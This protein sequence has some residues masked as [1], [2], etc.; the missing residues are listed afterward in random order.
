M[1]KKKKGK[2]KPLSFA[3]DLIE[4]F[5]IGMMLLDMNGKIIRMN[6]KQEEASQID[7]EKILGKTFEKAF[8]RTLEQGV[9]N[10][11]LK[12]LKHGVPFDVIIDR[13][14]PQYYSKLI[15]YRARG[16]PFSS[17]KYYILLH[18][19]AEELGQ[20]KRLVEKRTKE[21]QE[22]KNFLESMID[23]SPNIVVSTN[24]NNRI[25]IFNKTAEGTF[26]YT[27]DEVI[28]RKVDFL[29]KED[30]FGQRIDQNDSSTRW[31]I[32][33]V[34]KD[35]S[36]FPASLRISD[37]KNTR[38][39]SIAKLYL[40]ADLTEK[41][42]MEERLLLSEKLALYTE[43]MGGIAHQLNNPLIG[44]INFSEML[45]SEIEHEDPKRELVETISR[46]GKECLKIITSV[47]DSIKD[48]YLT[49][50]RTNMNEIL[51]DSLNALKEQFGDRVSQLTI[52]TV[53]DPKLLPIQGD[54]IQLK[55]CIL[56]IMTNAIQAMQNGGSLMIETQYDEKNRNARIL[57]SDTGPGIP[58]EFESKIFLPYFSLQKGPGRHG[59]G[60]SFAFQI[61]K[62][63]GG[64][65]QVESEV[66]KGSTFTI[67]LPVS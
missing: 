7:R 47:L 64:H 65:I 30:S 35:E 50:T 11:Y 17:R 25:L 4:N 49:F 46:A 58:K 3:E 10:P 54:G 39:R 8:P 62:N 36:T 34:R 6:K 60:L 40:L 37:I 28:K 22:S 19:H 27:E 45:L 59:L 13:Y 18:E 33:C 48:P 51:L 20:E 12:L 55:Q 56:N 53:T 41:K 21:V 2:T 66:G 67:V 57:F 38:G 26:G 61:V 24:F 14:T 9:R 5:P 63:H 29:F 42:E 52:N 44:V 32:T 23:S 15:T 1:N 43:L 16:A 31:E